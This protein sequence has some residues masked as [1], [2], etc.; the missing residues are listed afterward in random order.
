MAHFIVS[1]FKVI[2]IDN[3]LAF[4]NIGFTTFSL[5]GYFFLERI[6]GFPHNMLLKSILSLFNAVQSKY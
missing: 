6:D 3:T 2:Q 4:Y 1:K 5:E